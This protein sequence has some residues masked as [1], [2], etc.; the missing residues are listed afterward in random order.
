PLAP[1][2]RTRRT[3]IHPEPTTPT[4]WAAST[5]D[6]LTWSAAS[7]TSVIVPIAQRTPADLT[8]APCGI[9]PIKPTLPRAAE[10]AT[11]G[12]DV[13]LLSPC[14]SKS[15]S[16]RRPCG[17]PG[18]TI[19][20]TARSGADAPQPVPRGR[21]GRCDDGGDET[22]EALGGGRGPAAWRSRRRRR[23]G[24]RRDPG[25]RRCPGGRG[26]PPRPAAGRSR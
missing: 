4:G 23:S 10:T 19:R 12:I 18:A 17:P 21:R 6:L 25:A 11:M 8:A 13:P 16:T 9:T 22:C 20:I 5:R 26:V 14:D 2:L 3:V 7:T 24:G 1:V 15:T